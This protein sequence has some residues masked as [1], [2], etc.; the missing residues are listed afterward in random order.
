MYAYIVYDS[1]N[2]R[3]V[4]S[5]IRNQDQDAQEFY[6]DQYSSQEKSFALEKMKLDKIMKEKELLAQKHLEQEVLLMENVIKNN[7]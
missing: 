1:Y 3:V 6:Q 5:A 7:K 2:R 4:P